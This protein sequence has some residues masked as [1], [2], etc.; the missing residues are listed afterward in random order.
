MG[1]RTPISLTWEGKQYQCIVTMDVIDRLEDDLNLY[2]LVVQAANG[3]MRFS[4]ISKLIAALLNEGGCD[5]TTE[6]VWEGMF[7]AGDVSADDLIPMMETI[8]KAVYPQPKKKDVTL[9]RKTKKKSLKVI[10]T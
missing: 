9:K 10:G 6:Q 5:V 4:K 2:K 7:G 1:K 3:D 8:F